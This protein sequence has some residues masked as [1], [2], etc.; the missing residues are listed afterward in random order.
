MHINEK[1]QVTIPKVI[2]EKFGFLPNTEVDFKEDG[3]KLVLVKKENT[4]KRGTSVI[5]ALRNKGDVNM[6]TEEIMQYTR[7]K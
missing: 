7:N 6:T 2:R 4:T 3:Q 1:G 5:K